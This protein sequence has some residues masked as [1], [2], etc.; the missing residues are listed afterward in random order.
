MRK[1]L[2]FIA[3][4]FLALGIVFA[5]AFFIT[6][7]VGKGALQVTSIPR[8]RVFLDGKF[9]GV[10]PICKCEQTDMV[11]VGDYIIRIEPQETG[12]NPFEEKIKISKSILTV[13]D[14]TFGKG[15]TSEGSIIT[16]T[17]LSDSKSI[18]ALLIS[19]P[20]GVAVTVDSNPS[21][22]TPLLLKNLTESDHEIRLQKLGY[23]DKTIRV[24]TL[25]GYKLSIVAYLGIG[26]ST[27]S[28]SPTASPTSA[29]VQPI[30][31][32]SATP[33]TA[34]IEI[35]KTPTGFLRVRGDTAITAEEV[36]RVQPGEIY[37]VLEEREGWYKISLKDNV[38][39]G[40]ISAQYAEKID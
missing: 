24:R 19:F 40:W 13:V 18:E 34:R 11:D 39:V 31:S 2:L 8:S 23:N 28:V 14:R 16:L 10:T 1:V 4:L 17:P 26:M 30:A 38:T 21:G 33:V 5:G 27:L 25:A 9:L 37:D 12:F 32:P 36:G 3:P 29:I 22:V 35:L 15:V 7:N 6:R 20:D